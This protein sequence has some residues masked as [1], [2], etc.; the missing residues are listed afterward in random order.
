[1]RDDLAR[2]V[3]QRR[4]RD[5]GALGADLGTTGKN[6]A[7]DRDDGAGSPDANTQ[8]WPHVDLILIIVVVIAGH[9]WARRLCVGRIG[10]TPVP[11]G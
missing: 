2:R 9:G 1:M 7:A 8:Q 10:R 5:L 4:K 11:R 6:D 3:T